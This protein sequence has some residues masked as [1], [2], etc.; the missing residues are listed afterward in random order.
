MS[1]SDISNEYCT[2]IGVSCVTD[3]EKTAIA[4][5]W[6]RR[7]SPYRAFLVDASEEDGVERIVENICNAIAARGIASIEGNTCILAIFMDL[8]GEP[9][10]RML[11]ALSQVPGKL[12]GLLHCNMAA[13]LQFGYAGKI[14]LT[15]GVPIRTN[16][17]AVVATNET[18]STRTQLILVSK[19]AL[20]ELSYS[21]WL[22]PIVLLDIL[23]RQ[24][25]PIAVLPY[26]PEG[27]ANNDIGFLSYNE[28]NR[29]IYDN[30]Q[31]QAKHLQESIGDGN[32]TDFTNEISRLVGEYTNS[33]A[34]NH[35]VNGTL[36]P[37]H[38]DMK[39][40]D[41]KVKKA[42]KGKYGPYTNAAA[43]TEKAVENTGRMLAA[44]I[45]A[46]FALSAD[47][48]QR[49]LQEAIQKSGLGLL[50]AKDQS[51]MQLTLESAI[52]EPERPI[53]P[54]LRE[55][56][57]DWTAG[58]DEY[59][60]KVQ[61]YALYEGRKQLF[62]ALQEA[63]SGIDANHFE[64]R[65]AENRNK[66][67]EISQKMQGLFD[68]DDFFDKA[69]TEMLPLSGT[70]SAVGLIGAS[71]TP[72][73]LICGEELPKAQQGYNPVTQYFIN[74]KTGNIQELDDAP[75]KMIRLTLLDCTQQNLETLI[76]E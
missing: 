19:P 68:Y 15:N 56:R 35:P 26:A 22:P 42:Q 46:E 51:F 6:N 74:E 4:K 50:A 39:V 10:S 60:K 67:S 16:I 65:I 49:M 37:Q 1:I 55:Y 62:K 64:K 76:K 30:Y 8:S 72:Y 28:Y 23:R 24:Q 12:N 69:M 63:Y 34:E 13:V 66:F 61:R 40:P 29:R 73:F 2:L 11:E 3:E 5:E 36:Q 75:L 32:K 25:N 9:K 54:Y 71:S 58:I 47:E 59:L 48:A 14:G 57:A 53:V 45:K 41:N 33:V 18:A 27:G 52:P 70:L 7:F 17:Q 44:E 31:K 20:A 43:L 21:V 38:P